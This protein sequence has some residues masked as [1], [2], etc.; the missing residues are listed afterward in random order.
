[1]R[2]VLYSI[3]VSLR[4]RISPRFS[5]GGEMIT[6]RPGSK[7]DFTKEWTNNV[8]FRLKRILCG[9]ADHVRLIHPVRNAG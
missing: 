4:M 5:P 8:Y 3:E 1:M 2:R 7:K 6:Q 9:F